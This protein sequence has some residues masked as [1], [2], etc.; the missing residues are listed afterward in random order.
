M[1]K[2]ITKIKLSVIILYIFNNLDFKGLKITVYN[3]IYKN[4]K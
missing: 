3:K 4:N 1:I 2:H